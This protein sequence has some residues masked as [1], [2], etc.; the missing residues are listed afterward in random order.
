MASGICLCRWLAEPCERSC[1]RTSRNSRTC[2]NELRRGTLDTV[3]WPA[4]TRTGP[5]IAGGFKRS[6]ALR[7]NPPPSRIDGRASTHRDPLSASQRF[8]DPTAALI[9]I[10]PAGHADR[11]KAVV[12]GEHGVRRGQW[13][14]TRRGVGPENCGRGCRQQ[15]HVDVAEQLARNPLSISLDVADVGTRTGERNN[16]FLHRA[17]ETG[18]RVQRPRGR[19]GDIRVCCEVRR[20]ADPQL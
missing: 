17:A 1:P 10:E 7:T 8:A 2:S 4:C 14:W 20:D 11:R 18:D 5:E 13:L 15:Q 6:G 19:G 3:R 16:G 9:R 12:V